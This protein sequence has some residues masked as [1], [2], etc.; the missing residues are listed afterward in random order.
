MFVLVGWWWVFAAVY[1]FYFGML[2]L[3]LLWLQGYFEEKLVLEKKYGSVY[4]AYKQ[5]TGMF[6][7][8]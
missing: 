2:V 3:A 1:S 7:I 5:Q 6:W 8:K 4:L